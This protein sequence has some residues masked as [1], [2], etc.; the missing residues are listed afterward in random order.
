MG[1][2]IA[3]LIADEV[4]VSGLVCLGYPFHPV[5][6]PDKLRVEHLRASKTP[7]LILQGERD[8]F[9][10][11]VEVVK[12]KLSPS[13]KVTWVKD[14]DYSFKPRKS[15]GT[16]EEKNW[17]AA[18][19][20]IEAFLRPLGTRTRLPSDRQRILGEF[21]DLARWPRPPHGPDLFHNAQGKVV[22]TIDVSG[23]F[24]EEGRSN[25]GGK[26]RTESN[27]W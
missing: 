7:T 13:V 27:L 12:Y 6:K 5:S 16:T 1:G 20:K 14:G 26:K 8:P 24:W 3:S 9:G 4:G 18:A 25:D 2:R 23:R 10:N 22:D 21:I 19:A 15:S 17:R 11:R